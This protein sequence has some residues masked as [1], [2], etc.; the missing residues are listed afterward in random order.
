METSIA[1][2]AYAM[3]A[4]AVT[5]ACNYVS[6]EYRYRK[7]LAEERAAAAKRREDYERAE[8]EVKS[9]MQTVYSQVERVGEEEVYKQ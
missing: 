1:I 7:R 8:R 4:I 9:M 5:T 3:V 2:I 6:N